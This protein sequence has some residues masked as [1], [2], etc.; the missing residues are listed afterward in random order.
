M[1]TQKGR[2]I[3]FIKASGYSTRAF[4]LEVGVSNGTIA[5]CAGNLSA[6]LKEKVFAR[7]PKLNRDWLLFGMGEMLSRSGAAPKREKPMSNEELEAA[8]K[9]RVTEVVNQEYNASVNKF[10]AALGIRQTTLNDQI[11]RSA[12]ISATTLLALTEIRPDIS[13]EWLLRGE[14]DMFKHEPDT[15]QIRDDSE[16]KTDLPYS[17]YENALLKEMAE[18]RSVFIE[19]LRTKDKQISSLLEL[20]NK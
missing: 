12:K 4:E 18:Q 13:A 16:R 8:L 1:E 6:N 5:H 20:L 19:Q 11:N 15:R 17:N 10:A 2:L 3:T 7:F 14:G 9:Q